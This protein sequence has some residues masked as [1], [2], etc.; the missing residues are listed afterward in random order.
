MGVDRIDVYVGEEAVAHGA[1]EGPRVL[2]ADTQVFVEIEGL[3][4][5]E[6]QMTELVS[7]DQLSIESLGSGPSRKT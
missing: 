6:A 4:A 2:R 3:D 5:R 1:M 7:P